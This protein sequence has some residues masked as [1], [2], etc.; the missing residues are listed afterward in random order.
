MENK[1]YI[2]L[3]FFFFLL[4]SCV[5]NKD[6][7]YLQQ[8]KKM[9]VYNR[10]EIQEYK[11]QVND[12]LTLRVVSS[13]PSVS[14]I[15]VQTSQYATA[16]QPLSYRVYTDGTIDIPFIDKVKVEGIILREVAVEIQKRL[17]EYIPDA[18]VKVGL[19]NN[20]FYILGEGNRRNNYPIYKN[21][22]TI[23]E[24]LASAGDATVYAD[25]KKVHIIRQGVDGEVIKVFDLRSSSIIDSEYYY[26]QP[27]DLIYLPR[28]KASFFKIASYSSFIGMI[29]SSLTFLIVTIDY[30][31]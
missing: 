21:R 24:A 1:L 29:S 25:R 16:Q 3:F 30:T 2:S 18:A 5:T 15:F 31:K 14:N 11:I 19:A 13:D 12:E 9:P 27:N 6:T 10:A 22:L 20:V 28:T 17:R 26:I 7:R 8:D 23:F 4:T